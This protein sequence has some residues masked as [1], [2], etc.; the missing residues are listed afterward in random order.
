[1]PGMDQGKIGTFIMEC[2]KSRGLTQAQLAEKLNITD[3]AVSKWENGKSLP[4]SSIMLELCALLGITADELLRGAR[5]RSPRR[6]RTSGAGCPSC[7]SCW[8]RP[9]PGSAGTPGHEK[10]RRDPW[11]YL[12]SA[13]N[14][15][16]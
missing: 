5:N 2:R 9:S 15:Y 3:R 1:M 4:D 7:S 14:P 10:N 13:Q 6:P 12:R 8:P 16:S 11:G